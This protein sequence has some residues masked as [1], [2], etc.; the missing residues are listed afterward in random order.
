MSDL[1]DLSIEN[2]RADVWL[3]DEGCPTVHLR[4]RFLFESIAVPEGLHVMRFPGP[5][6]F[7]LEIYA[8]A[9]CTIPVVMFTYVDPDYGNKKDTH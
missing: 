8:D 2:T 4:D 5:C 6:V 7:R 3:S 1:R 9:A